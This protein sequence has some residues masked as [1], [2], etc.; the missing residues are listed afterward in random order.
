MNIRLNNHRKDVCKTNTPE[1]DQHFRLPGHNFNRHTKLT[2]IKQLNNTELDKEL[3]TFRLKKC[4]DFWI[5]KLKTLKPHGVNA[6]LNF[7][8]LNFPNLNFPNISE[9]V[10]HISHRRPYAE[11]TLIIPQCH[12]R[13]KMDVHFVNNDIC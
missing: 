12:S 5:H 1:A 3:L 10:L 8:N 11:G 2:L 4:E 6:K 13:K 7:P 9:F